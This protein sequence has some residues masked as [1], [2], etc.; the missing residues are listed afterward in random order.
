MGRKCG[1]AWKIGR[2][3][4]SD[5]V[6]VAAVDIGKIEGLVG[7]VWACGEGVFAPRRGAGKRG[8]GGAFVSLA[9]IEAGVEAEDSLRAS[10]L[11]RFSWRGLAGLLFLLI[12]IFWNFFSFSFLLGL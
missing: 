12:S 5:G 1:W 7:G 2:L 11:P 3:G 6:W 8:G 10:K 4:E 9:S